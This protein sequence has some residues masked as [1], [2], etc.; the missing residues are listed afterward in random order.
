MAVSTY[1]HRHHLNEALPS[2]E[3]QSLDPFN[4]FATSSSSSGSQSGRQGDSSVTAARKALAQQRAAEA[5]V[6]WHQLDAQSEGMP[7]ALPAVHVIVAV[8]LTLSRPRPK[9]APR[10]LTR[11]NNDLRIFITHRGDN[12]SLFNVV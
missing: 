6:Q 1:Q 7:H 12:G 11:S 3:V 10:R 9:A 8:A 4:E 2:S 5:Q